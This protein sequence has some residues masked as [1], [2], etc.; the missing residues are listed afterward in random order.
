MAKRSWSNSP[1]VQGYLH[2]HGEVYKIRH[3]TTKMGHHDIVGNQR[4]VIRD[5]VILFVQVMW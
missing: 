3:I 5:L 1:S 4:L 2:V